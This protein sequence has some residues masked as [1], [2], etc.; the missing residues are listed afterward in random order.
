MKRTPAVAGQFYY[1]TAAKLTQQ[2]ERCIV[3]HAKKERVIGVVS[4]HAGLMYSGSVAGAVYSAIEFPDTFILLGPNHTGLG[5]QVSLM[6]AGEWEIPT[7]ILA[8]DEKVA[9]KIA[10]NVPLVKRDTSAHMFEHSLEVQLPFITYFSKQGQNCA[11][12]H[13]HGIGRGMQNH[14]RGYSQGNTGGRLSYCHRSEH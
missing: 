11:A 1:G 4:P 6:D 10:V 2:V 8:I 13:A 7:G 3:P 14:W 5:A 9:H 12:S